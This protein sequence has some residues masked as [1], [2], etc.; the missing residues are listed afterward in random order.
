MPLP[1]GGKQPWPPAHL[2]CVNDRIA[3][4]SAWYSGDTDQISAVYGGANNPS[5]QGHPF[6]ASESGHGG[7]RGR[8]RN[9]ISRWFWGSSPERSDS[10]RTKLHIPLAGD[11]ASTS[12][13]ML[14]GEPIKVTS[15]DAATQDRLEDLLDDGMDATLLEG[16]EIGAA[17]SGV[18]LRVVWNRA[19]SD[20]PWVTSVHPDAAV[21]EWQMGRLSAVT[22]WRVLG[23]DGKIVVRHLERHE[24]GRIVHGVYQG[25]CDELGQ[26]IPLDSFEATRHLVSEHL[27]DGNSIV[28]GHTGLTAAYVPNARPN[29]IWRNTPDAAY[30]GRS[31]FSGVE[32]L[33]DALD[34]TWSSWMRDIR[35]GKGRLIVPQE[36]LQSNGRG[37]GA[38]FSA[39]RE[40]W[41]SINA[42]GDES[43]KPTITQVQFQIRV[44]EHQ[45]TATEL[46]QTIARS[47]GYSPSSFGIGQETVATATEIIS[48]DERSLTTRRRKIRY[49]RPAIRD[50]LTALLAVDKTVFGTPNNLDRPGI[51]FADG[52][53]PDPEAVARTIQLLDAAKAISTPQ[54]VITLHP[55]WEQQQ[56]DEEVALLDPPLQ[57]PATFTGLPMPP[58]PADPTV[59][60]P[61]ADPS[62]A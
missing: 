30:L 26:P 39:E 19:I 44:A 14:F 49:W 25:T 15:D 21:P 12:A 43:G 52:V 40:I 1:T 34:E 62:N 8:V 51:E 17:L 22:F 24:A 28:T 48:R 13:D 36:Y 54:K 3:T 38:G 59:I 20:R 42:L 35:L 5:A 23:E 9:A 11:I 45:Q 18:Y 50:I 60:E 57:D 46:V 31:D 7:V 33:F 32:P 16:A 2:A 47:A 55:D 29:R 4:W 6:F 58:T 41:T 10:Q 27:V 37:Q 61:P 53:S 56:V